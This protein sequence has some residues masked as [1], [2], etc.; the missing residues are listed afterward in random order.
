MLDYC[1]TIAV[2]LNE[3]DPDDPDI[4]LILNSVAEAIDLIQDQTDSFD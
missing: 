4:A 3:E 1:N 2:D